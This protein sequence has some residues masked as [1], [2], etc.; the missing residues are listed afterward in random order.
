MR[1]KSFGRFFRGA[2]D[3]VG[4]SDRLADAAQFA[5]RGEARS[6]VRTHAH[7]DADCALIERQRLAAG[8]EALS[9][10]SCFRIWRD[11]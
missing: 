9:A 6:N 11:H 4:K 2:S 1:S 7:R 5:P 8:A 3:P 10:L